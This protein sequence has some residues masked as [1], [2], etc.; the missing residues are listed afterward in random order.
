MIRAQKS[1][2]RAVDQRAR[3]HVAVAVQILGRRVHDEIGA[4]RERPAQHR[5][6]RGAVDREPRARARARVSAAAA[7]SVIDPGRVGRGLDPD[8]L[9]G[10]RAD[11]RLQGIEIAGIDEIDGQTPAAGE[12]REPVAQPPVHDLGGD[13]VIAGSERLEDRGRRRHAGGEEQAALAAVERVE[14]RLGMVDGR[15]VGAAVAAPAA[16]LVVGI[17]Q[18]GGG[19]VQRRDQGA[20]RRV[21]LAQRLRRERRGM[22]RDR[23]H[24]QSPPATVSTLPVA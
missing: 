5:G 1:S 24:G 18:I 8:E 4:E 3:D 2:A 14:Q 23:A 9:G 20:G 16:V 15:V 10:P 11:R 22:L 6:R 13:H 17:A 7:M 12:R 19:G 21:D